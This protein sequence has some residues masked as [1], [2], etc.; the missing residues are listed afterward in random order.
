MIIVGIILK[1]KK[2]LFLGIS[3]MT[4][5]TVS[6]WLENLVKQSFLKEY[7][8]EVQYNTINTKVFKP[9]VSDFRQKNGLK[10]KK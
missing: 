6:H 4:I 1:E 9:T 3:N 5:V 10:S 2:E 8:I 7:P